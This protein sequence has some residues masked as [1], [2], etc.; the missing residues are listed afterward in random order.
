[1]NRPYA[2]YD[3]TTSLCASCLRR[4]DA[5]IVFQEDEVRMLK[6]CPEHGRQ[7]V[8]IATDIEYYRRCREYVR[9]NQMPAKFSTAVERGCPYDCGLC[10]DH[11]QHSCLALVEITERCNLSCPT[12]YSM[13][14][15]SFGNHRSLEEVK[16]LIDSVV[17]HEGEPDILQ[18]SGGEPTIHPQFFEILDYARTQP[19][20]HLMVNTNGCRIAKDRG[21]AERLASYMPGFEIYLQFDS[22]RPQ[23]LETLRGEDLS[24]VRA[25]AL[26]VLDELGLSTTLVV[27]LQ[28]GLNDEEYGEI[29]EFAIGRPAVRGVTFQPTQ[30]TGRIENSD[31]QSGALS[32][33]E[34]RTGILEQSTVFTAEDLVPVPCHPDA[35][36]MAYALKIG[37]EVIPLT[38]Y[39]DPKTLLENSGSTIV[40]EGQA[41]L[42]AESLRVFS[43]GSSPESSAASLQSLLC[44]LPGVDAPDLSY[45]DVFRVIIMKFMDAHDFDVRSVRKS[46]VHIAQADGRMIPFETMNLLYREGLDKMVEG[47]A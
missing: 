39:V 35:L 1:M 32:L 22:L 33:T 17:E 18:I 6:R 40:F 42:K 16:T 15:P 5:K 7:E 12:C 44:C 4:V 24:S 38:R 9:A 3:S 2:Y 26:D 47:F 46:C 19:I 13:S 8:T 14:S 41:K 25:Q 37:G 29:I 28:K 20:K 31:A 21:F 36:C 30:Y 45:E 34:V 23:V 11:E 27:T 10:T 43:T